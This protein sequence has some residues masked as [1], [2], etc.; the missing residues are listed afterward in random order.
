[1]SETAPM[2]QAIN[3]DSNQFSRRAPSL[4]VLWQIILQILQVTLVAAV[5][6]AVLQ[7]T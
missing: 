5:A 1:M 4:P 7:A 3:L 6:A 2:L